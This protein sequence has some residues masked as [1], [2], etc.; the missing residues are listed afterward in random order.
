M[1]QTEHVPAGWVVGDEPYVS[2]H[3]MDAE[4]YAKAKKD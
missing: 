1:E 2:I 3:L 4:A